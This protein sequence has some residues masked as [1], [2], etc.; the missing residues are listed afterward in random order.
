MLIC[1]YFMLAVPQRKRRGY[2]SKTNPKRTIESRVGHQENDFS[3]S[4]SKGRLPWKVQQPE[5]VGVVCME[6]KGCVLIPISLGYDNIDSPAARRGESGST[7]GFVCD[8]C[9]EE[10]AGALRYKK[11]DGITPGSVRQCRRSLKEA[12]IVTEQWRVE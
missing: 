4:Q 7:A 11:L 5:N 8:C 1:F 3:R 10:L 6:A 12:Q 9:E 2:P